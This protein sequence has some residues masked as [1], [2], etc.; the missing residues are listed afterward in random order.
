MIFT[1]KF[2]NGQFFVYFFFSSIFLLKL[3]KSV[4]LLSF[5]GFSVYGKNTLSTIPHGTLDLGS[6]SFIMDLTFWANE[7]MLSF[8]FF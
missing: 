2:K 4:L 3:F 5:E 7:T 6:S 1:R 8:P